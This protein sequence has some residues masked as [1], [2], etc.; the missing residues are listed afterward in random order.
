MLRSSCLFKGLCGVSCCGQRFSRY[1]G[2]RFNAFPV[3]KCLQH[4]NAGF[5]CIVGDGLGASKVVTCLILSR[6]DDNVACLQRDEQGNQADRQGK[7]KMYHAFC[8][9]TPSIMQAKHTAHDL[10]PSFHVSGYCVDQNASPPQIAVI[11]LTVLQCC[12]SC[13][14]AVGLPLLSSRHASASPPCSY[15]DHHV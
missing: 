2:G 15:R 12:S 14:Q 1:G 4:A 10:L 8:A 3:I 5:E 6:L 7:T 11:C 9:L 13:Q